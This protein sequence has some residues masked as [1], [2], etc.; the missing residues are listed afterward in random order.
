MFEK[1]FAMFAPFARGE[2]GADKSSRGND[3]VD[4]LK[5]AVEMRR[6][7][8]GHILRSAGDRGHAEGFREQQRAGLNLLMTD[9]VSF[10]VSPCHAPTTGSTT[11]SVR[12]AWWG[13]TAGAGTTAPRGAG[14]CR[15][16]WSCGCAP[17]TST[18][19]GNR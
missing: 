13:P 15:R 4:D 10:H 6:R 2:K 1:T 12:W 3:E 8:P 17:G 16:S 18:G 11:R 5:R 7:F 9:N 19:P 14:R